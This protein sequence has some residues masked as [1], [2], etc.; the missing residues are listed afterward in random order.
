MFKLWHRSVR[1]AALA[2]LALAGA[3]V[4]GK[5]TVPAWLAPWLSTPALVGG[6]ALGAAWLATEFLATDVPSAEVLQR[7]QDGRDGTAVAPPPPPPGQAGEPRRAPPVD[8]AELVKRVLTLAS[9]EQYRELAAGLPRPAELDQALQAMQPAD[10]V[11]VLSAVARALLETG[12]ADQAFLRAKQARTLKPD[13]SQAREVLCRAAMTSKSPFRVDEMYPVYK[14]L[15]E[16]WQDGLAPLVLFALETGM[17]RPVISARLVGQIAELLVTFRRVEVVAELFLEKLHEHVAQNPGRADLLAAECRL[18]EA[19]GRKTDALAVATRALA[20]SRDCPAV[21]RFLFDQHKAAGTLPVLAQTLAGLGGGEQRCPALQTAI[22]EVDDALST[23]LR[24]AERKNLASLSPVELGMGHLAAGRPGAAIAPLQ[25]ALRSAPDA[26]KPGLLLLLGRAFLGDKQSRPALDVLDQLDLRQL[27]LEQRY[28]L[29]ADLEACDE[30]QQ[31]RKFYSSVAAV[32]SS[33]RD[34]DS[35]LARVDAALASNPK[36]KLEENLVSS[37][38]PRYKAPRMVGQGG[39]G[40]VFRATDEQTGSQVAIKVLSPMLASESEARRRFLREART[41]AALE[42]PGIVK[43]YDV[44][45]KPV[46]FYAMEYLEG[47]S[48]SELIALE[49]PLEPMRAMR[50]LER[51]VEALGYCHERGLIHRDIKPANIY[52]HRDG[53]VILIDFGL[54][55]A[56][57]GTALTRTGTMMGTPAYMSPEQLSAAGVTSATDLYAMGVTL[58]ECV[59][60]KLPFDGDDL[61]GQIMMQPPTLPTVHKPDLPPAVEKLILRCLEKQ[62]ARRYKDCADLAAALRQ[63]V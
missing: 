3:W 20:A 31:A 28:A 38:P 9:R 47:T 41:L 36:Q 46:P 2:A 53:R 49:G 56:A 43:I 16:G 35:C 61:M 21:Y 37:L 63:L 58:Y 4:A 40:V 7:L 1:L 11:K 32:N 18:R 26:Q 44:S 12:E 51:A 45:E 6:F 57:E 52:L 42:H 15:I 34:L 10:R 5:L 17:T 30:L 27:T 48:L 50:L 55:H 39:M 25:E 59:T 24:E 19:Q 33:F 62:P 60:R 54:V 13:A 23:A 8:P 14:E 22:Q 29:A